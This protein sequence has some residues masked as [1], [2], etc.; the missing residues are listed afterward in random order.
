MN[1]AKIT[2][3]EELA[4]KY[5]HHAE[6][7]GEGSMREHFNEKADE[8]DKQIKVEQALKDIKEVK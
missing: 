6:M 3:L 7:A 8:I 5:R 2:I 4:A 1:T